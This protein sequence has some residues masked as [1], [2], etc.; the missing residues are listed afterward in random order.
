MNGAGQFYDLIFFVCLGHHRV[1][2][3]DDPG[4]L[5]LPAVGD[6][7]GPPFWAARLIPQG[8]IGQVFPVNSDDAIGPQI[9]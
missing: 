2:V 7:V 8:K 1:D 3:D 9:R 5:L 6:S 4:A